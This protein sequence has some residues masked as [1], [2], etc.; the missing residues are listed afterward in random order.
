MFQSVKGLQLILFR[1]FL[2]LYIKSNSDIVFNKIKVK[3]FIIKKIKSVN[4]LIRTTINCQLETQ[5]SIYLNHRLLKLLFRNREKFF[6]GFFLLGIQVFVCAQ[7]TV[8]ENTKITIKENAFIKVQQ[9]ENQKIHIENG[10]FVHN[11]HQIYSIKKITQ[12]LSE[13]RIVKNRTKK[14]KESSINEH[15]EVK[16]KIT[17]SAPQCIVK[18]Q[19]EKDI[20]V[21]KS[22]LTFATTTHYQ[23]KP[24]LG[25][26]GGVSV[27]KT[28]DSSFSLILIVNKN[29]QKQKNFHSRSNPIRPPPK[30]SHQQFMSC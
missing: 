1:F 10:A 3:A 8:A 23:P 18:T 14:L 29:Q 15:V 30:F 27:I 9:E 26:V 17:Q 4:G 12:T 5:M 7:I 2:G 25:V 19:K 11:L 16:E 28:P 24:P 22:K 20:S 13:K 21:L 6:S